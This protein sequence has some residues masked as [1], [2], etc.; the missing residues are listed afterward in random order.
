MTPREAAAIL[1]IVTQA[2]PAQ[3]VNKYTPDVWAELLADVDYHA[4]LAAVYEVAKRQ[5]FISP[6]AIRAEVKAQTPSLPYDRPVSDVFAAIE[7]R[8]EA[9]RSDLPELPPPRE[10]RS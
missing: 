7:S 9:E 8:I 5:D 4:A 2:C 10:T 1:G 3:K 6:A